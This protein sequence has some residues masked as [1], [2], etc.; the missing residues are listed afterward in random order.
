MTGF[1]VFTSSIRRVYIREVLRK[2][3]LNMRK[4]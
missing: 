3:C 1:H 4:K 2:D